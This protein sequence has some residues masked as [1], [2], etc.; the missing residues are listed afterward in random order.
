[1]YAAFL[2][3]STTGLRKNEIIHARWDWLKVRNDGATVISIPGK[4][5]FEGVTFTT[6]SGKG[7]DVPIA[8]GVISELRRLAVKGYRAD[9]LLPTENLTARNDKVWRL[10]LAPGLSHAVLC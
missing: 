6:K 3:A 5:R 8:E 9:Y 2:I 4:E 10:S 1:M 7:R